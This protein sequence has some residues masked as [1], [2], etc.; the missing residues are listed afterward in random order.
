MLKK[1]ITYTDFDGNEQSETFYFNLTKAEL[2]MMEASVSG[3]M[4]NTLRRMVEVKDTNQMIKVFNELIKASIGSKSPDGRRF[5]KGEEITNDFLASPAYD[6]LFM[7]LFTETNNVVE[8]IK[9]IIPQDLVPS[10]DSQLSKPTSAEV[11]SKSLAE[12]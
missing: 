3:G 1:T 5:I 8:F 4:G 2:T 7:S 9:S 10:F 11:T 12:D 6:S